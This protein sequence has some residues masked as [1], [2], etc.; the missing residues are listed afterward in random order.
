MYH[1]ISHACFKVSAKLKDAA[2][3]GSACSAWKGC[4]RLS[5]LV[6]KVR[7]CFLPRKHISQGTSIKYGKAVNGHHWIQIFIPW[8]KMKK[9]E[10]EWLTFTGSNDDLD[11]VDALENH[12][13]VNS[14]V[15]E[16]AP[17]F[18][19]FDPSCK[20]GYTP[21]TRAELMQCCHEIWAEAGLTCLSGHSFRIR[22]TTHLLTH[23]VEPCIVMKQGRWSSKAFLLYWRNI[24]DILP[25]FIGDSFDKFSSIKQSIQHLQSL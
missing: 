8:S 7:S 21:L 10:G 11:C 16:I 9:F 5:E 22:G 12:L 2:I 24:E 1:R 18:S 13:K 4:N 17:F 14:T 23:G 15:P 3:W 19:Y 20:T 6:I 25:L